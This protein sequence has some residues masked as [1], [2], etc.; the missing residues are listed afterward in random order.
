MKYLKTIYLLLCCTLAMAACS[1]DDENSASGAL[2]ITT[3]AYTNVGYNKAT[4]S[5]NISGTEG[6]NI[7]K[8]GFCY[9][10]ASHPDIYDTTSEVRGSEIS[11]TLTGLT[12]QTTYYV[13]AFVTL[14]NEEPRYSE[15]TSFTTPAETLS[16]ELAAYE[17][18][19]YVDDYTSFSA[20]SN[21]YDWNLANVHDPTVMKADDGYYYMYQTDASYGNAHS[22]NGHFHAR[23]SKDLVNWEHRP[24]A[25]AP[26]A[27]GTIF[28]GS[29]VIDHHNTAGFGAG[30]IVAIYTQN[31]DRQVQ[32]IAYST[33]NGRTF[34]KYENNPV[35]VSEARDFR[36]P[37][38]FWYEGTKRWIMVLAVG[39]EMQF[40]SSP[41]LKDWTFES[42]FGKGH[43][44]HGNVW[45][46]PDLFELPVEGTNEKK[47]VLLC[48]LGDGPFG[49]SATQYFVGSFN[50]KEFVNESPSKTKWMDWGKDHYATVTWSDAP[51][52]RR[53]A[54]AWM[55]NWQYANDVPTSQYRSPNS[56]PRDLSLFTVDGETY[57]QSAPSPELLKLR[58]VSKKRSFKVNG[59]SIIKD[60]IAGNE[61]AYEIELTIENQHADVIGFRLY[62]DKGEEVDMQYDMKEKKFS[63]DRRK[64]G[65]VGF[66][67]NF[68]MLTWT[69]IESGK[70]ELKLRLFV[71][72]SS[73]EAFG[74]GGRFVMTNQVFP[75]EPYTHIDFY[76]K[77]GAYKVDSFV[78]Y[79]LKK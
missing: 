10:T 44:A 54:I 13:R 72:K 40:F 29:A 8:R 58:D 3:P 53:I 49:D 50:G 42:S 77:G 67:E 4:L 43:G 6:V 69:A 5:A 28:S 12:P 14:Y 51:D 68:P 35:L 73:V 70:D 59:T 11:T 61:G 22:G 66:N 55:S 2:S 19:T 32:S 56:V 23:R 63:M 34:T 17:A 36:D 9:A 46:C 74:D 33:D 1:D 20:W 39:Q 76:S 52:N 25:I 38:V 26:D 47:W 75:S 18:P 15:E 30:A 27:F 64:S 31:G 48:S 7:V 45:E 62:N 57:L 41:N 79:K 16:D 71:D 24:V 65:D 78:I 60:M 37:K 21:R